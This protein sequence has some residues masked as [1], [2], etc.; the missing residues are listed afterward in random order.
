V[1]IQKTLKAPAAIILLSDGRNTIGPLPLDVVDQAV[2]SGIRIYTVGVGTPAGAFL[3]IEGRSIFLR[4]DEETLK[5]IAERTEAEYYKAEN[6]EELLAIYDKL[7]TE[8][9]LVTEKTELT[10]IFTGLAVILLLIGG[11]FSMYWFNRLP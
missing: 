9:V 6:A 5:G 8:L 11:A 4:F 10:A 2:N 1:P 3:P 7:S